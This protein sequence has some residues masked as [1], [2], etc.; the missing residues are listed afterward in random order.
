MMMKQSFNKR[1]SPNRRETQVRAVIHV[2]GRTVQAFI[3]DVSYTGMRLS[4]PENIPVGT[5]VTV[6]LLD[7]KVAAIV[8]WSQTRFAGVHLL[9]RLTSDTLRALENA[10]D[11][12]AAYR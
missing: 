4:V 9:E 2:E 7:E 5:P 10:H 3:V 1:H 8:H 6:E 12:L 11:D